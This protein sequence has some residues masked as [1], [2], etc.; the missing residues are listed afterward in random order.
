MAKEK[1]MFEKG[2]CESCGQKIQNTVFD[3]CMYCGAVL[4]EHQKF[5]DSEKEEILAQQKQA[6]LNDL[7]STKSNHSSPSVNPDA[8]LGSSVFGSDFGGFCD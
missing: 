8:S 3:K 5:S 7:E 1:C 4:L 6:K 2:N